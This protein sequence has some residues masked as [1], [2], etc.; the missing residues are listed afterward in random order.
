M[1][2]NTFGSSV[3]NALTFI[4]G[5][6]GGLCRGTPDTTRTCAIFTPEVARQLGLL[7][8][9]PAGVASLCGITQVVPT[10]G[11]LLSFDLGTLVVPHALKLARA[12]LEVL[13]DYNSEKMTR[14]PL[15]SQLSAYVRMSRWPL[16]DFVKNAKYWVSYPMA[17]FLKN[18]LPVQP[19]P[20]FSP[21]ER[22]TSVL[23]Q[24]DSLLYTGWIK[25]V[26]K[27]RLHTFNLKN[28]R[29]F[30]G[31]L[32]G[33]KRGAEVVPESFI[34]ESMKKHRA[35]LTKETCVSE[36]FYATAAQYFNRFFASFQPS[37]PKLF[38]AS[39]SASYGSTR[40]SGGAREYIRQTYL[41]GMRPKIIRN[42]PVYKPSL[43]DDLVS[44]YEERPGLVREV[45]GVPTFRVLDE[46]RYEIS[47]DDFLVSSDPDLE[48][49]RP[50]IA[51]MVQ[52]VLEPLK[53]RLITKGE[54]F[55]YWFSRFM[56]KDLW[57]HLS[58]FPQFVL[59]GRPVR[60]EDIYTLVAREKALG[61]SF[62]QWVSGDYSAATD[63]LKIAYTRG[64]FETALLR[65]GLS[66]E[67]KD[68]LRSVLYEQELHYP[69]SQNK[70]HDLDPV[71]QKTGQLMGSPLSFPILCTVNLVTYWMTLEARLGRRVPL[72]ALPVLVNGDDILFRCDEEFYTAWKSNIAEVGF[73][74]SLGKN[75]VHR[76]FLTINSTGF[77]WTS[78]GRIVDV[79]YLNVGLLTGQSKLGGSRADTQAT[80][81]WG[82][83]NDI[84]HGASDPLRAHRRFIHY[85]KNE[86][87]QF[88]QSG[89]YSPFVDPLF[90][91][92]GF[93]LVPEVEKEVHFTAF[94]RRFG[95][96]LRSLARQPVEGPFERVSIFR[97]IVKSNP[98]KIP[99]RHVYHYCRYVPRDPLQPL[100]K[101]ESL[102]MDPAKTIASMQMA[103]AIHA[104]DP[105]DI[106]T[107]RH[108]DRKV[109]RGFRASQSPY[110]NFHKL[111]KANLVF[112]ELPSFIP[113][114]TIEPAIP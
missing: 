43:S 20:S 86:I 9:N 109:L 27:N 7:S 56:Q 94:Q 103:F 6:I 59:T 104:R 8:K 105:D 5:I 92:L 73:E 3:H 61:L 101:G 13:Y 35:T 10:I 49:S 14:A 88:T 33:V 79:P 48:A 17:Y 62:D 26:L 80:P 91:G 58:K 4:D 106:M 69:D 15:S 37:R 60:H 42:R 72:G 100:F 90:G 21:N 66:D 67:D 54:P 84:I 18:D 83:Y 45:R 38:E 70:A 108:P 34:H 85:Q 82:L 114:E 98:T 107:I 36:K 31:I 68:I 55:K 24:G 78:D 28:L 112:V 65:S 44:M 1:F 46:V 99:M 30:L 40:S 102:I 53:V 2:C 51:V 97:G 74:L 32:Q 63:N 87:S 111:L 113:G 52:A 75:Y 11:G 39:T 81:I 76:S 29:L 71:M 22:T 77:L 64:A 89:Q 110:K 23:S 93:D 16:A 25:R 19:P 47:R 50:D 41:Q 57:N 96:Y 12:S 95:H